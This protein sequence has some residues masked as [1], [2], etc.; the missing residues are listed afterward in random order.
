MELPPASGVEQDLVKLVEKYDSEIVMEKRRI[1]EA[2]R[3][4]AEA[5]AEIQRINA[6]GLVYDFLDARTRDSRYLDR[7]GLISIIR[8]DFE[9]LGK[10]SGWKDNK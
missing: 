8:Q 7:L 6:G 3:Q 4:I 10:E 5:Q 9:K 2:D 1:E